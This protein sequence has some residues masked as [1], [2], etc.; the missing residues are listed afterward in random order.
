MIWQTLSHS[1]ERVESVRGE[2]GR[3]NPLVV[4]LMKGL[5]NGTVMKA[6]VNV[7]NEAIRKEQEERVLKEIV[8]HWHSVEFEIKL[9]VTSDLEE[10]EGCCEDSHDWESFQRACDLL[11]DLVLQELW[12]VK[13]TLVENEDVG[14]DG[15]QKVE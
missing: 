1:I 14:E 11:P 2:W 10:E 12:V 3:H 4:L 9:R 13:G 6:A 5:V 15:A 7:V 8:P